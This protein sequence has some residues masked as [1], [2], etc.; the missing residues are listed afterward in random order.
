MSHHPSAEEPGDDELPI[1]LVNIGVMDF[2]DNEWDIEQN[3]EKSQEGLI[4]P[5]RKLVTYMRSD[6]LP[7][8]E[9]NPEML[10]EFLGK[11]LI[12]LV[13]IASQ[14]AGTIVP[15]DI[16]TTA[17]HLLELSQIKCPT[18]ALPITLNIF[19]KLQR[20]LQCN[21]PTI[22]SG[23]GTLATKKSA[24]GRYLYPDKASLQI[25]RDDIINTCHEKRK[26]IFRQM[27]H[28]ITIMRR[29]Y[30]EW[31]Q[32]KEQVDGQDAP[33]LTLEQFYLKPKFDVRSLQRLQNLLENKVKYGP[34]GIEEMGIDVANLLQSSASD[35]QILN[36]IT[37][38]FSNTIQLPSILLEF[39][40]EALA[41]LEQDKLKL[42]SGNSVSN[43]L[44]IQACCDLLSR[45]TCQL[46]SIRS[47]LSQEKSLTTED[48]GHL[49]YDMDELNKRIKLIESAKSYLQ[50][51]FCLL[52]GE[53]NEHTLRNMGVGQCGGTCTDCGK[54]C[55]KEPYDNGRYCNHY[56]CRS[57]DSKYIVHERASESC[58]MCL[59]ISGYLDNDLKDILSRNTF[60]RNSFLSQAPPEDL[61]EIQ[62]TGLLPRKSPEEPIEEPKNQ[63]P[64]AVEL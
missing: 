51:Q 39:V 31:C 40:N 55:N 61:L 30:Y 35:K 15:A 36:A 41:E 26:E 45:S 8:A 13:R 33:S 5:V 18:T 42:S 20:E 38:K 19:S 32:K 12:I 56:I 24:D 60:D 62:Y 14:Q 63:P 53:S 50:R 47:E 17:E 49:Y 25:A 7:L 44:T 16:E 1:Q 4:D 28:L 57:C 2:P 37:E 9:N 21:I 23:L 43:K 29:Q 54:G 22:L 59:F 52:C 34:S 64:V 27:Q 6:I 3:E 11:P 58:P 10:E 46:H 48:G